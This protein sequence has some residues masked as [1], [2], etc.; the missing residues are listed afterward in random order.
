MKILHT[1]DWHLRKKSD[2]Y[3]RLEEQEAAVQENC[4]IADQERVAEVIVAG[5]LFI[6]LK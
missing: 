3:S 2:G 6:T 1:S 5:N 4:S